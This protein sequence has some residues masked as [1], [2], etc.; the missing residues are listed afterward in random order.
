MPVH[1]PVNET[2]IYF[3]TFTCHQWYQHSSALFYINGKHPVYP[4]KDYRELIYNS[5]WEE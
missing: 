1:K 4:V 3:I 5:L 2:G